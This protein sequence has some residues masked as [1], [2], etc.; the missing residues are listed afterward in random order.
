MKGTLTTR[1]TRG[2][3]R[4]KEENETRK[5]QEDKQ[6]KNKKNKNLSYLL[7][8]CYSLVAKFVFG[9]ADIPSTRG[10]YQGDVLATLLFTLTLHPVTIKIK[11]K[12]PGL[13][14]NG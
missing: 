10:F 5:E 6:K 9:D 12:V 1:K 8:N 11:E 7:A 3:T 13:T 2:R 14:L 4:N